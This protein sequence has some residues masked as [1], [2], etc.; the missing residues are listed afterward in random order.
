MPPLRGRRGQRG[1]AFIAV[2]RMVWVELRPSSRTGSEKLV[3]KT[4][5]KTAFPPVAV[6]K[7]TCSVQ[8]C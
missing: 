3:R 8:I 4:K 2:G 1:K 6:E 5:D 7:C